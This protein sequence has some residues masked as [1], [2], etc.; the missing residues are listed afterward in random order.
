ML[1]LSLKPLTPAGNKT[2]EQVVNRYEW[3]SLKT[4]DH[5]E[6]VAFFKEHVCLWFYTAYP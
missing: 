4:T 5:A 2:N 6:F 1:F 3:E